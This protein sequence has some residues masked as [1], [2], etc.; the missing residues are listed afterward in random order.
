MTLHKDQDRKTLTAH[1]IRIR[2]VCAF[3][4]SM[5][6]IGGAEQRMTSHL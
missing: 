5:Q 2:A 4:T 3:F 1:F 6:R